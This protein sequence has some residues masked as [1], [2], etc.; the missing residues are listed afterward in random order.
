[1]EKLGGVPRES[2]SGFKEILDSLKEGV[3]FLDPELHI[4]FINESALCIIDKSFNE[5]YGK[6]CY[7]AIYGRSSPCPDC[8]AVKVVQTGVEARAVYPLRSGEDRWVE[9]NAYP[10][11]SH[12]KLAGVTQTLR[13]VTK[14]EEFDEE[15]Y[16][17]KPDYRTLVETM[18]EGLW[19]INEKG[20]ITYWNRRMREI[21]GYSPHEALGRHIF[22]FIDM[23]SRGTV[24][25]ELSKGRMGISSTYEAEVITKKGEKILVLVSSTPLFDDA[26]NPKGSFAVVRD[27]SE[28]RIQE[29]ELEGH[30]RRLQSMIENRT[31]ELRKSEEKY[32]TLVEN[33]NDGICFVD[34]D[35]RFSFFNPRF[36][37]MFGY[38]REELRRKG[39][40]A[41]I[42]E[43]D[44]AR[45]KK[46]HK[47]MTKDRPTPGR[48]EY[49]GLTADGKV[50]YIETDAVPV[51]VNGKTIGIQMI[52][53]DI[54]ERQ[55]AEKKMVLLYYLSRSL[56]STLS[57]Q[58]VLNKVVKATTVLLE[59]FNCFILLLNE[60]KERLECVAAS[61][62]V[63]KMAENL[64]IDL[65]DV[66]LAGEAIRI[67]SPIVVEE[68]H[69]SPIVNQKLRRRFGHTS[70]F[71]VPLIAKDKVLGA[72]ILG[73][74]GKTRRFTEE[75]VELA[76]TIASSAAVA[77]ENARLYEEIWKTKNFLNNVIESSADSIITTDTEG[78]I[79]SFSKGA[80][81]LLGL[82][83]KSMMGKSL[84][85]IYPEEFVNNRTKLIEKLKRGETIRN[86][87]VNVY[88]STGE[89][90]YL[91][92]SLSLL[93]DAEGRTIGT[94][95]VAR[96]ITPEIKAREHLKEAYRRLKELD[97]LK[98][99]L[100]SNVSHELR[101][102]IT[103]AKTAMELA[104]RENDPR[105]RHKL[106]NLGISAMKR[107]NNIVGD[108]ICIHEMQTENY[109]LTK[110]PI[111][112]VELINKVVEEIRPS[113]LAKKVRLGL[114]AE[115]GIPRVEADY[116]EIKHVLRNLL[117]NAIK[118]NR[119]G[120]RVFIEIKNG[121]G[122][123]KVSVKDTG[124]GIPPKYINRIF[125]RFY[126]IDSG[127]ERQYGGT[128]MGLTI[129]KNII[130][131][132]KGK[133]EVKSRKREGSTFT[134]TLPA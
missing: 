51:K 119:P 10:L 75:E 40:F 43:D 44:L 13:E 28:K 76:S 41:L 29:R 101:T 111:D 45:V 127:P 64:T 110:E 80:E 104:L 52:T 24:N 22:S 105:Q 53:R 133:V 35:G 89:L 12:G 107:Q 77:I 50:R 84:L 9:L 55:K 65:K 8:A 102:P 78:R 86:I 63:W 6:Q 121:R 81:E 62:G 47:N 54:T 25:E 79:T 103:I 69:K 82:S 21:M 7:K 1:V 112:L 124:I 134:F 95:E 129:V 72:I 60:K 97:K 26:G 91:S 125:E 92:L 14:G 18:N 85:D 128:G 67:R 46:I 106:L 19:V 96:D 71:A 31:K 108:L 23:K 27:I 59:C 36:V 5:V 93:R 38:P 20:E 132:H 58:E 42:H 30:S 39:F 83:A 130:E 122:C 118:F 3:L 90:V 4:L 56:S 66:S 16:D 68:A 74:T 100:I 98:D 37:D 109:N 73:E 115:D 34:I 94:V 57:L 2:F 48:Y 131:A 49:R 117:D 126:Q 88:N 70:L 11:F 15:L 17:S 87:T 114:R 113:A 120:G 116:N 99:E 32:R 33:A 123:V 61:E